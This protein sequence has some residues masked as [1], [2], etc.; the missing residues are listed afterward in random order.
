MLCS[1]SR[2]PCKRARVE[3]ALKFGSTPAEAGRFP[4][5]NLFRLLLI[6]SPMTQPEPSFHFSLNWTHPWRTTRSFYK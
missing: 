2:V 5:D 4:K 1:V 6:P 3:T